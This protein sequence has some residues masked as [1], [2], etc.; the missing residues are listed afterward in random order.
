MIAKITC[1]PENA[2][3][4]NAALRAALPEFHALAMDLYKHGL[5]DGLR[6]ATLQIL[7]GEESVAAEQLAPVAA[8]VCGSCRHWARDAIGDGTGIGQCHGGDTRRVLHWP[9]QTVCRY[10]QPT[11]EP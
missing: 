4:F 9:G 2:K 8:N 11:G 1:G 5:I 3:E 7:E 10:Y 6:G